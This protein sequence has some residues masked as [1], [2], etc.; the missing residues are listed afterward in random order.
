MFKPGRMCP[1]GPTRLVLN[2]NKKNLQ[3][4]QL[5]FFL[6]IIIKEWITGCP[7]V[8]WKKIANNM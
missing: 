4:T 7:S 5:V 2:N 3:L 1:D 6:I 8:F